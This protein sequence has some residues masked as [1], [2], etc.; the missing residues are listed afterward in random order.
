MRFRRLG[1]FAKH[2]LAAAWLVYATVLSTAAVADV[3][4]V[5]VYHN[6]PKVILDEQG[7]PS[8]IPGDLLVAM[9]EEEGWVLEPVSCEWAECLTRLG[10]GDIDLMPDVGW[11]ESRADWLAVASFETGFAAVREGR[12][13]AAV[14]NHWFGDWRARSYGLRATPIMFQPA[15]L[16]YASAA[17]RQADTLARIDHYLGQWKADSGSVYFSTLK[18]WGGAEATEPL[19]PGAV[20]WSMAGLTGM[21]AFA[22]GGSVWLRRKVAE[23][24]A[25]LRASE[26]RLSTIL[27]SVEA[28]I[29]I[30]STDFRYEYVN[31]KACDLLGLSIQ[32]VVGKYDVDL[33]DA[34]TAANLR[35][36][37]R[38]VVEEGETIAAEEVNV[39]AS[40][41]KPHTFLSVKLPLRDAEGTVQALCG[42]AT[43]ITAY[44][45]IQEKYQRLTFHD[46]LTGLA[47]R[48]LL[49]D[50]LDM[51]VKGARRTRRHAALM[52]IDLDNFKVINEIHG[53][54]QG[55]G[56]LRRVAD[57][58]R[59][60]VR[61]ADTLARV[62]SDEFVLLIGDLGADV[63]QAARAAERVAEKLITR[64]KVAQED[65]TDALKVNGS[66]G[67]TLFT[68]HGMSAD[69]AMQQAGMALQQAKSTGGG[70]VR[71]FNPAMQAALVE[72][73]HLEADLHQALVR[74]ELRLH[75][76]IRID[77]RGRVTRVE[78]LLRWLHPQRGMVPP[79]RFIPLAEDNRQI[80]PI[81]RWVLDA[82]CRQL[83]VWAG[84]DQTRELTVAVNVSPVQFR[85]RDFV[86]QVREVLE[87]TGANPQCLVLEVT[88]SL[89]MV[90]PGWV[91]DTMLTLR[92][93]GIRFAL[94]DFG[95]GYSS[96]HYLKRLP[97]DELKID[98]SFIHDML[99][100][101]AGS[102]IVE[103]TIALAAKLDL[104]VTAEGVETVEQHRRLEEQGCRFFQG[105]L[106]GRP[107]PVDDLELGATAGHSEA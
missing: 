44:R 72:R 32:E 78:A 47:N 9:A 70:A 107:A 20:W 39:L 34:T 50:R 84:Q 16:Y 67:V 99:E 18:R 46:P 26:E 105:Y 8:G 95:T 83:A 24:T 88:E 93:L 76:Q 23:R 74:D 89:L 87:Q 57:H 48:R 6:P 36:N 94:D 85:Q 17:G 59:G 101:P 77:D 42:I 45:E 91:R 75:Y 13:D 11:S 55:D 60:V 86:D 53:H 92:D 12:A 65:D 64:I 52:Y 63:D 7:R 61:E 49:L 68:N 80:L 2:A 98:Q 73:A 30:K 69:A 28:C 96:L 103:A 40:G 5:G 81:G 22:L 104:E 21:L 79:G 4:R 54:D 102:A 71:F 27:D 3:L 15:R 58:M 10:A 29:F 41:G 25:E 56:L 38:R 51:A 37:D 66:I 97:L 82:A 19:V 1:Y 35:S 62:G 14:T 100:D 106:F 90:D 31:R 43:D 33:F